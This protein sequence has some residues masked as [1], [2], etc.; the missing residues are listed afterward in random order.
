MLRSKQVLLRAM[1]VRADWDDLEVSDRLALTFRGG[2]SVLWPLVSV[3]STSSQVRGLCH[4]AA[5][6]RPSQVGRE[7]NVDDNRCS[8]DVQESVLTQ[9]CT[10]QDRHGYMLV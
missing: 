7:P 10:C 5:G 9:Q 4:E 3:L 8:A 2:G 6:S 1:K